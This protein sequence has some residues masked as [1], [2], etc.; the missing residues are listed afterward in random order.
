MKCPS[1]GTDNPDDYRFCHKCGTDMTPVPGPVVE[2]EPAVEGRI[3]PGCGQVNPPDYLFCNMCGTGLVAEDEDAA[4]RPADEVAEDPPGGEGRDGPAP[5]AASKGRR[6]IIIVTIAVLLVAVVAVAAFTMSSPGE[7]GPDRPLDW[8]DTP[9]GTYIYDAE[10]TYGGDTERVTVE[11]TLD[12]GRFTRYAIDD[13]PVSS[14]ELKQMNAELSEQLRYSYSYI[15]GPVWNDGRNVHD[16]YVITYKGVNIRQVVSTDGTIVHER[17]VSDGTTIEITLRGWSEGPITH[18]VLFLNDDNTQFQAVD[19]EHGKYVVLPESPD[20]PGHRHYGWRLDGTVD[21]IR[22][23]T[24]YGPICADTIFR[25]VWIKEEYRIVFD[26]NG[27]TGSNESNLYYGEEYM[28]SRES[29]V[30]REGYL[31][32]GWSLS[33]D[34]V[35]A[36]YRTGLVLTAEKDVTYYAVW[37]H[38]PDLT[39]RV[40]YYGGVGWPYDMGGED[41]IHGKVLSNTDFLFSDRGYSFVCWTYEGKD[42]GPDTPILS[43]MTLVGRWHKLSDMTQSGKTVTITLADRGVKHTIAWGDGS[44][45]TTTDSASHTY[46]EDRFSTNIIVYQKDEGT[47]VEYA[48]QHLVY[49]NDSPNIRIDLLC[50]GPLNQYTKRSTWYVEG[51]SEVDW[52]VNFTYMGRSDS[53]DVNLESPGIYWIMAVYSDGSYLHGVVSMNKLFVRT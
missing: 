6:N 13:R 42:V 34:V 16:T 40:S 49:M 22:S 28:T 30:H 53:I 3:C 26:A 14:D 5:K 38:V 33:P 35:T 8:L 9:D 25:I 47:G 43:D 17:T 15:D 48:G 36:S 4:D 32:L 31:L 46:T 24:S 45:S 44:F 39:H 29:V 27:G 50:K 1:C 21:Q 41:V 51:V 11:Y 20:K 10:I 52:Y 37:K 18:R 23:G 19:V 7:E 12:N 2:E